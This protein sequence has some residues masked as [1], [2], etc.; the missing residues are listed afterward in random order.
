MLPAQ[1]CM[2]GLHTERW[3]GA[4]APGERCVPTDDLF[5]V[6]LL[7]RLALALVQWKRR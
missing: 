6:Q 5:D 1:I 2:F 7:S 3:T 4:H